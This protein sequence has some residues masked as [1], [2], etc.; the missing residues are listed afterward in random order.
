MYLLRRLVTPAGDVAPECGA[1]LGLRQAAHQNHQ[2]EWAGRID[3]RRVVMELRELSGLVGH[4]ST[5]RQPGWN[6]LTE[7]LACQDLNHLAGR[8]RVDRL[9][10]ADGFQKN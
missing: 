2:D 4:A 6:R 7:L 5:G 3:N 1:V 9:A 10:V 8:I